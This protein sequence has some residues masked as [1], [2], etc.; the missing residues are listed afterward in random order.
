MIKKGEKKSIRLVIDSRQLNSNTII[1]KTPIPHASSILYN[2]GTKIASGKQYFLSRL[3]LSRAYSQLPINENDQKLSA[4]SF[5]GRSWQ[6]TR[7]TYGFSASPA[8]WHRLIRNVFSGIKMEIFFDDFVVV[9]NS[10]SEHIEILDQIFKRAIKFG[11]LI[12]PKKCFFCVPDTEVLGVRINKNGLF[13]SKRHTVA[14]EQ[15]PCP[16][17]KKQVK[18]FLGLAGFVSR[19]IPKSSQI[20]NPLYNLTSSKNTFIWTDT[21]NE[22]FLEFKKMATTAPGLCHRNESLPLFVVS[23]A[24]GTKISGILYQKTEK[25]LFQP[26]SYF[27][28]MLTIAERRTGSRTR[29]IYALS[30]SIKAFEFHLIGVTFSVITD[31]YSLR[32]LLTSYKSNDLSPRLLNIL[33]YLHRHDFTIIFMKNT[34]EPII[35]TDALTKSFSLEDLNKEPTPTLIPDLINSLI[36]APLVSFENGDGKARYALRENVKKSDSD[37]LNDADFEPNKNIAFQFDDTVFTTTEMIQYQANDTFCAKILSHLKQNAKGLP[38]CRTTRKKFALRN[39]VLF[40]IKQ[41]RYV[42]V[43]PSKIAFDFLSFYHHLQLHPGSR[44]LENMLKGIVHI[45]GLQKICQNVTAMCEDCLRNKVR[46]PIRPAKVINRSFSQYPFQRTYIDLVQLKTDI[47]KK[48]YLLTFTDELSHY[49]D[50][51]PISSKKDGIVAEALTKLILRNGAFGTL[52]HDRGSEFIGPILTGICK[53]LHIQAIRTSAYNSRSNICERNHREF[54]VKFRLLKG[55]MKSWSTRWPL[56]RFHLNSLPRARNDNLS[57]AEVVFGRPIYLP[58][59]SDDFSIPSTPQTWTKHVST[60]F[61]TLY[62]QLLNF[63]RERYNKLVQRDNG[64]KIEL[65]PGSYVLYYK[66]SLHNNKY[67]SAWCG[68]CKI[69]KRISRN[70]Y[71]I[72]DSHGRSFIRNIRNIRPVNFEVNEAETESEPISK[73]VKSNL[74]TEIKENENVININSIFGDVFV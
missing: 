64:V 53:K 65:K 51:E 58:Y 74:N 40:S 18:M 70:T 63:Q 12:D 30:D 37:V 39:N 67:V 4:F 35:A 20:L 68:P 5:E 55:D 16:T 38:F 49:I 25:G 34:S 61:S 26:L 32:W 45:N 15:Y 1:E 57:A 52:I 41:G 59:T 42:L 48:T 22:S 11:M 62:P 23:D 14:I 10:F 19:H 50:G 71:E 33:A 9:T 66:P 43:L 2:L 54:W 36:L 47:H 60:Y 21:H 69:E 31:H 46:K 28:R 3:D 7:M 72:R 24:S 27:S 73:I 13:P 8:S 44:A 29:E 56:I 6:P 17:N